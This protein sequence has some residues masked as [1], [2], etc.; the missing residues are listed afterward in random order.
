MARPRLRCSIAGYIKSDS[1]HTAGADVATQHPIDP[2]I[3]PKKLKRALDLHVGDILIFEE[4]IGPKTGNPADADP[5]RRWAVRLTKVTLNE[6]PVITVPVAVDKKVELPWAT[7]VVDI[8]W[9]FD[10]ALPFA[11]CLSAIVPVLDCQYIDNISVARGNVV[12]VDHG[13]TLQPPEPIGQVPLK[14]TQ[15]ACDCEGEQG[16]ITL[17]AD[18]FE[19]HLSQVPLTFSQPVKFDRTSAQQL[20]PQEVRAAMPSVYLISIPGALDGTQPLFDWDDLTDAT[21]LAKSIL[22][23]GGSPAT[24]HHGIRLSSRTQRLLSQARTPD[25]ISDELRQSLHADLQAMLERWI[26]R[27]DL[28]GSGPDDR[29][30]V[31]EIDNDGV[32]H[33]RFGD[34]EF[35]QRPVPG[36]AFHAVYRIGNGTRGNLGPEAISHFV[37]R[38]TLSGPTLHVRNPLPAVGG[39]DPEP[40]AEARLFAPS[41][42]RQ[43]L[44][45]AIT[46]DDYAQIT[47]REFEPALQRAAAQ[48]AWTGSWY[49]ADVAIDPT[50]TDTTRVPVKY[51]VATR[52]ERYRR[53][54]HDLHVEAAHY[55]PLKIE[56]TACVKSDYLRGHVKA[57]LLDVFSN[58]VLPNGAPGFFH[59]DRL[60]FGDGIYLSQIVAAAQAVEG[61]DSVMVT[62]LQRQFETPN[63]EIANGVLPLGPFEIAQVDNDPN[64]PEQGH[65]TLVMSGGR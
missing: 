30:F 63:Q 8:E 29:H 55:V 3:D 31:V 24:Y 59:P 39:V 25:D 64:Y 44:E 38:S 37:S 2:A 13:G 54:G 21:Q 36:T 49:E 4:V 40:I 17:S 61:V 60:T 28:L 16:D 47:K 46:A 22:R 58:R 7:P 10:D 42:F 34:D 1:P 41:L 15:A 48:L 11:L 23:A 56:V 9:G 14:T 12:L 18:R 52:L 62:K 57:A 45:R 35:G 43:R 26:P 5:A 51:A 20:V 33:L 27:P 19:P 53:M 50:G 6:D 65:F 32:A